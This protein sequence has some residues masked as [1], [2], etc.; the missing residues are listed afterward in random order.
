YSTSIDLSKLVLFRALLFLLLLT[1][2]WSFAFKKIVFNTKFIISAWPLLLFFVTLFLSLLF[3]VNIDNSWFGSYDRNEGLISYLFYGLWLALVAVNYSDIYHNKA[4]LNRLVFGVAASGFLV[5]VYA[6]CQ[7]FGLDTFTWSEPAYLTK[8]AFSSFGQ[9]NY[10][11][12]WLLIILPLSAYLIYILKN[13]WSR[14]I[15]ILLFVIELI[16]LFSTG[17]RSAFLIFFIVSLVWLAYF[18][19]SEKKYTKKHLW[20]ATIAILALFLIFISTLFVVNPTRITELTDFKK[21][22]V[23]VRLS[24]WDSGFKA[25]LK[26]PLFGYGLENQKEVY[27]KYYEPDWAIYARPN[28][29]SDRAHNLILDTLLTTGLAGLASLSWLLWW[30]FKS[31]LKSYKRD[32]NKFSAF[33]IWSLAAYLLVL[34]FNFSITVTNI[35]FFLIIA[36]AW[37]T[38]GPLFQVTSEKIKPTTSWLMILGITIVSFYGLL[39]EVRV[40]EGEYYFQETLWAIADKQ[41]F[42][43]LV[44]NDYLKE[45]APN[46]VLLAYYEQTISLILIQSLPTIA[47][48]SSSFVVIKY[49]QNVGEDISSSDFNSQFVKAFIFGVTSNRLK[50]EEIF[51]KLSIDSPYLPKIYLAWGD[52]YLFNNNPEKAKIKFEKAKSVLPDLNN[53]YLNN[54]QSNKLKDYYSLID[55]RLERANLL[56]VK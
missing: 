21:G 32:N 10:L 27:V 28:T 20:A 31:L 29:Y 6:I 45:T 40:L 26:K 12:C 16:A 7:L 17:S 24:L 38:S 35:Y 53:I 19:L 41:Y 4:K 8:R 23:S 36:L 33:I 13:K 18:L 54:D 46:P 49:L 52:V 56:L 37:L 2:A 30:V 1:S 48:K 55:N 51:T 9:P 44:L 39:S 34:M 25:F 47:D 22:S 42:K 50:S 11:A 5:S 43:T 3:S 14:L 15:S